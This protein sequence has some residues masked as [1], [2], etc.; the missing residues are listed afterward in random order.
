LT[1]FPTPCGLYG[2]AERIDRRISDCDRSAVYWKQR[3]GGLREVLLFA[4]PSETPVL[5]ATMIGA[6]IIHTE[7]DLGLTVQPQVQGRG[8]RVEADLYCPMETLEKT[9]LLADAAEASLFRQGALFDRPYARSIC[10]LVFAADPASTAAQ[11]KLKA[12]F[13]PQWILNPGKLCF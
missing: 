8:F 5:T 13:D 11:K 2:I 4:P 1:P 7:D 12:V 10:A 9:R 3:R 6:F